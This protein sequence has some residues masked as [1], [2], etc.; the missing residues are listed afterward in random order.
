M[1]DRGKEN[2]QP[3]T[4]AGEVCSRFGSI[5]IGKHTVQIR[6][7]YYLKPDP[8]LMA[9]AE[10]EGKIL[11]QK[12]FP[13]RGPLSE[14][15]KQRAFARYLEEFLKIFREKMIE[16]VKNWVRI[17]V[18]RPSEEG[19][20]ERRKKLV[21]KIA[22]LKGVRIAALV[23]EGEGIETKGVPG[24]LWE[25]A[26]VTILWGKILGMLDEFR[27]CGRFGA[28][29]SYVIEGDNGVIFFSPLDSNSGY[30]ALVSPG[31]QVELT[32][33]SIEELVANVRKG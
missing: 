28:L 26:K 7:R 10:R 11:L 2:D 30:F 16:E 12:I 4:V 17:P 9:L 21:I 13:L 3:S 27:V 20:Y 22:A 14:T 31:P 1:G 15:E 18:L 6:I 25:Q 23:G 33:R 8:V 32:K 19:W 24:F 5:K 29:R